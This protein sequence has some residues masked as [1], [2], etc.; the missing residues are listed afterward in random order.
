MKE[1]EF[2]AFRQEDISML[3]YERRFNDLLMFALHHVPT[4][5][6]IGVSKKT[7]KPIKPRKPKK[8]INR[9]NRTEKK[10]N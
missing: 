10:T 3:E 9:K 8:K 4:K 1:Y 2:L 5:Q 6:H 7:E